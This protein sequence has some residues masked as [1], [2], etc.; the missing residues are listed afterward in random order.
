MSRLSNARHEQF[1]QGLAKGLNADEA[2]SAAGF[3]ANRGNAATLKQKQSISKRVSELLE[4]SETVDRKATERAVERLSITKERVLAELA[5]IG[6]S[7]IR[8][9][10]KWNGVVQTETDNPDGGDVRVIRNIVSNSVTLID[11]SELD[12]DTAAAISQISQNATGGIT[13]KMHDKKGAL[14]DI[15]RHLGMFIDRL[16]HTGKD[17]APLAPPTVIRIVGAGPT[18]H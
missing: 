4:W 15:G 17:G 8:K 12:D 9:A 10:I 6:F 7:D 3:K 13:L 18:G 1:A 16:E 5:K 2:Y 11:S 14:V